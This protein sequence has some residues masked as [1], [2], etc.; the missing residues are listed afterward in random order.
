MRTFGFLLRAL[1]II[2]VIEFLIMTLWVYLSLSNHLWISLLDALLLVGLS[3]PL[4]YFFVIRVMVRR[5]SE[6]RFQ[7]MVQGV[8]AVVWEVNAATLAL[9]FINDRIEDVLGYPASQCLKEPNFWAKHVH[10]EDRESVLNALFQAIFNGKDS[11]LRY[12]LVAAD[13]RLVSIRDQV[14]QFTDTG[15]QR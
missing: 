11:V 13:G 8:Q 4:L 2:A 3:G 1:V 5:M 14:T 10:P 15:G 7:E 6:H 12:R 9:T